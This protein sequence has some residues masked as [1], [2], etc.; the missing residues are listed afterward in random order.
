MEECTLK[1]EKTEIVRDSEP[2]YD[3]EQ[4]ESM[5]EQEIQELILGLVTY[6]RSLELQVVEL[7]SQVNKLTPPDQDEPFPGVHSD[8]YETFDH[9]T[10]YPTFKHILKQLE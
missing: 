1:L 3:V 9:Y 10:A 4:L 8:L 7:R 5:K 2:M 6:A